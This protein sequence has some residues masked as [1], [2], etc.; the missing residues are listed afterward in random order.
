MYI[1]DVWGRVR[2]AEGCANW[3]TT[4]GGVVIVVSYHGNLMRLGTQH[5]YRSIV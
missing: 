2:D 1:L 3:S 5:S 4:K